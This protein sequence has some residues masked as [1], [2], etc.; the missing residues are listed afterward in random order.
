MFGPLTVKPGTSKRN[1]TGSWRTEL[2]PSFLK[3]NC[4]GCKICILVCPEACIQGE[5]KNTYSCDLAYCKGCGI[6]AKSCPKQDVVMIKE[7]A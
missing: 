7:E 2:K 5:E 1:K 4:I 6:C 3:K